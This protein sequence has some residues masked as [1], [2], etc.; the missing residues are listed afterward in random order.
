M[1]AGTLIKLEDS[2]HRLKVL[3]QKRV[4]NTLK[5]GYDCSR[6]SHGNLIACALSIAGVEML[7][8]IVYEMNVYLKYMF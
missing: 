1:F 5:E 6:R 2:E 8:D 3:K 7:D 4:A